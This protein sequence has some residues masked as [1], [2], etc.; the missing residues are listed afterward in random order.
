MTRVH[1]LALASL[2]LVG[3]AS[4]TEDPSPRGGDE[5]SATGSSSTEKGSPDSAL[6][7]ATP[8]KGDIDKEAPV[9]TTTAKSA[10]KDGATVMLDG[11]AQT[12]TSF[13][14]WSPDADGDAHF[15]IRFRGNGAPDGTDVILT[16]TK[17]A[18]GCVASPKT[19]PQ[20]L[21]F[22][23]PATGDQYHSADGTSCGLA[24]T[25]FPTSVG[26]FLQGTF[27]GKLA[28]INGAAG[29]THTMS[30]AFAFRRAD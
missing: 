29:K 2:V 10:P 23:P 5:S 24:I 1:A 15:F 17:V 7:P 18:T 22:R 27:D 21:W 25:S 16:F 3:C 6:T 28:G 11:V 8:T 19:H 20:D 13:D 14:I 9:A 12:V 30:I 4:A 26:D